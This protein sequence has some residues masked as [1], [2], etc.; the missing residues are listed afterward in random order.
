MGAMTAEYSHTPK[1]GALTPLLLKG[2]LLL[3]SSIPYYIKE[4]KPIDDNFQYFCYY[5]SRVYNRQQ[6]RRCSC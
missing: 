2:T 6:D 3:L 5:R 1:E 4:T